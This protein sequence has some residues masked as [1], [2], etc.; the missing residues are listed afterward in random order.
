M[1]KDP[2]FPYLVLDNGDLSQATL[3]TDPTAVNYQDNIVYQVIVR[4]GDAIGT[5]NIETS[6][7]YNAQTRDAGT[8]VSLGSAYQSDINGVGS[9][10]FDLN[11]LGPCYA[12]LVYTRASGSGVLDVYV[13]GKQV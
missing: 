9:G 1:K 8:W 7:N 13:S 10:I 5:V 4:S 3:T 11:Q 12:R 6:T 2:L